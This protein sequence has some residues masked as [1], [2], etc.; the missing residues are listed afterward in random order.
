MVLTIIKNKRGRFDGLDTKDK[1]AVADALSLQTDSVAVWVFDDYSMATLSKMH[2]TQAT[3]EVDVTLQTLRS[4]PEEHRVVLAKPPRTLLAVIPGLLGGS[5]E[6]GEGQTVA[7][8]KEITFDESDNPLI[9][10]TTTTEAGEETKAENM[11]DWLKA[12]PLTADAFA[13]DAE[14]VTA[15][16]ELGDT[17]TRVAFNLAKISSAADRNPSSAAHWKK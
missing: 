17:Q 6:L 12:F 8:A 1:K 16:I 3:K 5:F 4:T 7:I 13:D 2:Q 14:E 11:V 15:D 10:V 9:A